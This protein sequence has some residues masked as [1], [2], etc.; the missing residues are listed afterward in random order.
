MTRYPYSRTLMAGL[1]L[2]AAVVLGT[3]ARTAPQGRH[4]VGAGD[5]CPL[6]PTLTCVMSGLDSPRG[7]AFGPEGALYVA[8]A[9]RGA[10]PVASQATD[11][12]CFTVSTGGRFCYGATGAVTRLW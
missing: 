5:P 8:E 9:G 12:R 6:D 4:P 11:P 3:V 10:G 2:A 1:T 7:L